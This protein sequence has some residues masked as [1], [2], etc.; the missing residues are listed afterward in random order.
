[1]SIE[2]VSHR[3]AAILVVPEKELQFTQRS[4]LT[5]R[6]VREGQESGCTKL[7]LTSYEIMETTLDYLITLKDMGGISGH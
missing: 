5:V 6:R 4:I 2:L 3:E 7:A 1:M